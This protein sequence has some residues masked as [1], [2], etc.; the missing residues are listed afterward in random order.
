MNHIWHQ[1]ELSECWTVNVD[2]KRLAPRKRFPLQLSYAVL[3]KFSSIKVGF[4]NR[5]GKFLT[6]LFR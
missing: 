6:V 3:L 5:L 4:Q 1:E 2:E